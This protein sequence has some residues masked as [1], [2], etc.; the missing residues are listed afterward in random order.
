MSQA[1]TATDASLDMAYHLVTGRECCAA[2]ETSRQ[3]GGH[4]NDRRPLEMFS[5]G[6]TGRHSLPTFSATEATFTN[7]YCNFSRGR[8][9]IFYEAKRNSRVCNG[10]LNRMA[11]LF[12]VS[13]LR[14]PDIVSARLCTA[15]PR[16]RQNFP[17]GSF[18]FGNGRLGSGCAKGHWIWDLKPPIPPLEPSSNRK[19]PSREK[20]S[21]I[22][23]IL[24][25]HGKYELVG[26]FLVR[27]TEHDRS[28]HDPIVVLLLPKSQLVHDLVTQPQAEVGPIGLET[29]KFYLYFHRF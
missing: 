11:I 23:A 15:S 7:L 16:R 22:Q 13:S 28:T 26:R 14:Q 3:S 12:G 24:T 25:L 6:A 9:Y 2:T 19:L 21:I 27:R 10:S 8:A 18:R 29:V 4:R 20:K 5:I 17:V 1:D